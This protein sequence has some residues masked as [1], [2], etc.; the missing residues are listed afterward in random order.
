VIHG[1]LAATRRG[2]QGG[3]MTFFVNRPDYEN[4]VRSEHARF[5]E[6][7]TTGS[8]NPLI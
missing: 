4:V 6:I 3:Y 7:D 5:I 8:T 1:N 2:T